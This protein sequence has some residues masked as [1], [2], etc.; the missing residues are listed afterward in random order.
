MSLT[1]FFNIQLFAEAGEAAGA[2]DAGQMIGAAGADVICNG[3]DG[4]SY[5]S[6]SLKR[7]QKRRRKRSF[8]RNESFI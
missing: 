8:R 1:N 7:R 3:G 6:E 5:G 4:K 2:G